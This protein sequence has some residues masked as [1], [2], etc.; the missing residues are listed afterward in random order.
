M[1]DVTLIVGPPCAGKTTWV[2]QRAA[3]GALVVDWDRLAYEAGSPVSHDHAPTYRAA[4]T[5]RRTQLEQQIA[6]MTDGTAYVIRTAAREAER[7]AIATRLRAT[8]VEVLDPGVHTCLARAR[9][10]DR[11]PDVDAAILRWYGITWGA[12]CYDTTGKQ[13]AAFNPRR[14]GEW[15]AVRKLVLRGQPLCF[16]GH[17]MR[18]GVPYNREHP[19]PLYPTV[20][21]IV[22]VSRGGAWYDLTN[23]RPAC[24]EHNTD[25]LG[26]SAAPIERHRVSE[27]W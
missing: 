21:H 12:R 3:P 22:P 5:A 1:R 18:Y 20:D 14:T 2:A 11:H 6:T 23:L 24:W 26:E 4:A 27:E 13:P 9:A 10:T 16:R 15:R 7:T 17:P 25:H 19:D 8:H